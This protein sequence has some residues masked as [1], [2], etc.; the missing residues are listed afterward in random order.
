MNY[1]PKIT[2]KK[3]QE[4]WEKEGIYK[5]TPKGKIFSLD[6]PPAFTSGT[7]HMGHILDY[8]W[9]DFVARFK[10]MSGFSVLLPIGF[11]CHGLPTELKVE[12]LFGVKKENR[13]EFLKRCKEW[14]KEAIDKMK[15]QYRNLG[16]SCDWDHL[17]VTMSDEYKRAVQ[18]SLLEFYKK[19]LIYR[20]TH[21][22][23]WCVKCKT[24]LA[25][26]EMGY[27]DE[28]G[29]LYYFRVKVEGSPDSLTIATTRPEMLPACVAIFV[30][31]DDKRY[32]KFVGKKAVMPITGSAVPI[33]SD[34]GVDMEFG[35]GVVYLCTYGDE[36]DIRWQK[37]YNLPEKIILDENGKLTYEKYNGMRIKHAREKVV[38]DLKNEG[39]LEKIEDIT[40]SVLAHTERGTCKTPIEFMPIPQFFIKVLDSIDEIIKNANELKWYPEFMRSHLIDWASSMDWDWIISRQRVFGTPVP[41]WYCKKCNAIIPPK[42][43]QL[44]VD[45]A[46]DTPKEK[47][48]C[49]GE[50]AGS[51]DICDCWIDSSITPLYFSGWLR[52][53]EMFNKVYPI[54]MRP[55]GGEIIRTWAFYTLFR[56]FKL[57]GKKPWNEML[58]HG[59]VLAADGKKMSKS[60]GNIVNPDEAFE[61]Y[62]GDVLRQWA[63]T[64]TQGED[65]PF[66]WKE[67]E[68]GKKFMV[69]LWNISNFIALQL[70]EKPEKTKLTAIDNWI[71]SKFNRLLKLCNESMNNYVFNV[72]ISEIRNFIW[73]E[74]ADYYIEMVKHRTYKSKDKAALYT[75]YKIL[76]DSLKLLAVFTP[77]ITEEI[78]Q[79]NFRKFEKEKSIHLASYPEP[80]EKLIDEKAEKIGELA[81]EIIT[82]I[83][84]FKTD[85]SLAMNA[86]L[87]AVIIDCKEIEPVLD[88][89]KETTKAEKIKIGK[90][91]KTKTA[92]GICLDIII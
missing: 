53:N 14:T 27:I 81:K 58:L 80:D 77:F 39:A 8:S 78:Y 70:S 47:C 18:Y 91:D 29:K 3:W 56:C 62:S 90:A 60:T 69:K 6:H 22:I 89:I 51:T 33:M 44:P 82:V 79:N 13:E 10:R 35:T 71:L 55:Q 59:M 66:T 87:S 61:K 4:F 25:K 72:P 57:T 11:D 76:Y 41:F 74:F 92:S 28:C 31:P 19:G 17:Y 52:N 26:A 40:H 54:S 46:K 1:D 65:M 38:E 50:I 24:A 48:S 15:E 5:F 86:P 16:Y 32:K 9:I 42:E 30:H 2:E 45:P 23:P 7:L 67:M 73:H 21:P 12:H 75:L 36:Q 37:K 34:D 20:G 68:H 49:G 88:D 85:N 43:E 84:K 63:A 64:A 83:R